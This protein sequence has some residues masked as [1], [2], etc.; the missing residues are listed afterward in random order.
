VVANEQ[1]SRA[2]IRISRCFFMAVL[3][4]RFIY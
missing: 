2:E 3:S 4:L 1:T